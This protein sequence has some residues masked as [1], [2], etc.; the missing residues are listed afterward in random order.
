MQPYVPNTWARYIT[1]YLSSDSATA[2]SQ[3]LI[4]TVQAEVE[5]LT[6][7]LKAA[8]AK[9]RQAEICCSE[10]RL[11]SQKAAESAALTS[12]KLLEASS[13]QY[14][15]EMAALQE[16]HLIAAA[17]FKKQIQELEVR[18]WRCDLAAS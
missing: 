13:E 1:S 15:Q 12:Q 11:A 7:Q 14:K 6:E 3:L 10:E 2:N 9:W 5:S 16:Q 17:A 18:F 8:E 4:A